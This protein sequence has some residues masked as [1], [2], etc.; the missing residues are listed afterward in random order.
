[1]TR[2]KGISIRQR[3]V[4]AQLRVLREKRGLSCKDVAVAL[5]C[6]E[7]KVSRMETG[8]RGLYADDVAAI[9][10]FLCAPA[11]LRHELVALV[12]DGEERNWHEIHGKLPTNWKD[13]IRFENDATAIYNYE[14]M[15]IPGLAQIPDYSR[16]VIHGSGPSLSEN[17]L[18]TLVAARMTRQIILGRRQAPA[19]HLLIEETVLQR[20]V[21]EP[22][23]LRTQLRHLLTLSE[24]PKITIQV[25]PFAVGAHPGL[26]G[27]IV[28]LE[29][30]GEP[31]LAYSETFLSSSFLE[32][33]EHVDGVKIAWR[34]LRAIAM[35]P[36]DS[37]RRIARAIG[38]L[39]P[40]E[41]HTDHDRPDPLA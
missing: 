5:G 16:A 20:P 29:F 25:V 37:V 1:M 13:L 3:R 2:R 18:E 34:R 6:S 24:R 41:E 10:G 11:E 19:V 15:L 33:S 26:A 22:D 32:E 7:S 38:E 31:T 9:L 28:L 17:D 23:M 14:P 30:A 12:R 36:E 8:E 35:S 39:T 27:P 21:G 40:R 4:S